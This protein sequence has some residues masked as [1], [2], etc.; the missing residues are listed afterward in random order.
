MFRVEKILQ[1][2]K[3]VKIPTKKEPFIHV[4]FGLNKHLAYLQLLS[5]ILFSSISS[6][7]IIL[8][9]YI[10]IERNVLLPMPC[11]YVHHDS[12]IVHIVFCCG[13]ML[14]SVFPFC[15]WIRKKKMMKRKMKKLNQEYKWPQYTVCPTA[16]ANLSCFQSYL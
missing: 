10:F 16:G 13:S 14:A 2:K 1:N 4:W 9:F 5:L 7:S 12:W 11:L 15:F 6:A 3:L 8:A